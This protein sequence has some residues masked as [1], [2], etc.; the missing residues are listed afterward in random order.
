MELK[1]RD[2]SVQYLKDNCPTHW[3][4]LSLK[5]YL[6]SIMEAHKEQDDRLFDMMREAVNKA[7]IATDKRFSSVN[8]FRAQLA[9]QSRLFIIRTEY[10]TAHKNL[11]D[12][13]AYIK[14]KIDKIENMKE[15][16]QA[17]WVYVASVISFII[18]LCSVI[19]H[20]VK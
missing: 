17:V 15:G 9:D 8:E 12:K 6:E 4:L 1:T 7:D 14:E 10:E 19:L 20:F 16:G 18:A 11:E 3:S 13:I 2:Q 5:E